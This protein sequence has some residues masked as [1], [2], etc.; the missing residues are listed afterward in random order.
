MTKFAESWGLH[1]IRAYV[2]MQY[3]FPPPLSIVLRAILPRVSRGIGE[4]HISKYWGKELLE[5]IF[6]KT[7]TQKNPEGIVR[8]F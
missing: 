8:I 4:T 2:S 7:T 6:S 5:T 3:S 1:V